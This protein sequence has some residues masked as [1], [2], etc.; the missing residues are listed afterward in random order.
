MK[1]CAGSPPVPHLIFVAGKRRLDG[2]CGL[3]EPVASPRRF[4]RPLCMPRDGR[5]IVPT[6]PAQADGPLAWGLQGAAR[7]SA[8]RWPR[9]PSQAT[10]QAFVRPSS[11]RPAPILDGSTRQIFGAALLGRDGLSSRDLLASLLDLSHRIRVRQ[12]LEGVFQSIEIMGTDQDCRRA[13]V[14]GQ[15]HPFV[16]VLNPIDYLGQFGFDLCE[17]QRGVGHDYYYSHTPQGVDTARAL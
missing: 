2:R 13:P 11:R 1:T 12:D 8:P 4:R 15:R 3:H 6:V 16:T 14:P 7:G 5:T 17:G 10:L 9:L